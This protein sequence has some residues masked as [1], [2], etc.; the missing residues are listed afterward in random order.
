MKF[1]KNGRMESSVLAADQLTILNNSAF[2]GTKEVKT[3]E[4]RVN[5]L[6]FTR[7]SYFAFNKFSSDTSPLSLYEQKEYLCQPRPQF[8]QS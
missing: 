6:Q 3:K 1:L 7:H 8:V 5:W 4:W 2:K